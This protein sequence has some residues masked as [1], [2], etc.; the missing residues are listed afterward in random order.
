MI[1]LIIIW[2]INFIIGQ[3]INLMSIPLIKLISTL[4]HG[5]VIHARTEMFKTIR[6]NKQKAIHGTISDSFYW[7]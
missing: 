3:L 6:R 2:L 7:L 5:D 1:K 4:Y